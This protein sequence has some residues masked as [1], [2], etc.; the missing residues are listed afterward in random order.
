MAY[1]SEHVVSSNEQC[2]SRKQ[3]TGTA[4]FVF[5]ATEKEMQLQFCKMMKE[6]FINNRLHDSDGH[7]EK[8]V[9]GAPEGKMRDIVAHLFRLAA[10][11]L[12]LVA[13]AISHSGKI[14]GH[15]LRPVQ[16]S[17]PNV[18]TNSAVR[19]EGGVL[20]IDST[21]LASDVSGYAGP[22][23][24]VVCV[25]DGRVVSVA[26]KLPNEESP[27]FFDMLED[28]GLWRAWNGLSPKEAATKQ[29]DVVTSATYSSR[30]AIANARAAFA[31]AV[32]AEGGSA[33]EPAVS[34]AATPLWTL[35]GAAAFVVLLAAAFVPLFTKSRRWRTI[36]LWL[37][38]TVL[39]LWSGTFLS[40]ARLIGWTGAGLPH[41]PL[42][43]ITALL[44][45]ATALLWP[46]F[47]R[48][49]HYCLHVC[50]FGAAQELTSRLPV[51]KRQLP[52]T[53]VKRLTILRRMLWAA[54][55]LSLWLG[56]GARWLD[57][58]LFGVFAWRAASPLVIAIAL[59]FVVLS[60][61]VPRP[62]CRF[63]C[64]TGTFFKLTES[65]QPQGAQE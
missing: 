13:G 48:N 28:A 49:A 4:R 56:L 51:R 54:L 27:M 31:A 18:K 46:L 58:E 37:D 22:V 45:L 39:G 38:L 41:T 65:N 29:V 21:T 17:T 23:P 35:R 50:P 5:L 24:V 42:D 64:P 33:T 10:C 53:L 15:A 44:L 60:L 2:Q 25:E 26:P 40:T 14:F 57:W 32:E 12:L 30:A 8:R 47:G 20:L 7:A 11:L 9:L 63:V 34:I 3:L 52:P 55:M 6:S 61:F 43:L 16:E 62:Y 59:L 36:Q 1:I 19:A